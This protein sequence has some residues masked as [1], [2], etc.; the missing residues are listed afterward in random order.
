MW[1]C[2]PTS[3]CLCNVGNT[4][5]CTFAYIFLRKKKQTGPSRLLSL[6][7]EKKIQTH[8]KKN[9]NTFLKKKNVVARCCRLR[10]SSSGTSGTSGTSGV[11]G[12]FG[13]SPT[14][15]CSPLGDVV[16]WLFGAFE[17]EFCSVSARVPESVRHSEREM[18]RMR[19]GNSSS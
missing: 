18:F 19:R 10:R 3:S 13:T 7:E 2:Q 4:R 15:F 6:I 5:A 1:C 11:S 9:T 8:K 14:R 16:L 17:A 12:A